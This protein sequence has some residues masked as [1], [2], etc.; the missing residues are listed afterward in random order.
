MAYQ[1]MCNEDLKH[2]DDRSKKFGPKRE[3]Y[4]EAEA[5]VA[6]HKSKYSCEDVGV[7]EA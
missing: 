3:T 5:D 1:M 7:M 2:M 6:A 4:E